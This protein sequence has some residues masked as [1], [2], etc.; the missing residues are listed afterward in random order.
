MSAR[1]LKQEEGL[2]SSEKCLSYHNFSKI[3]KAI[4]PNLKDL[5]NFMPDLAF[6]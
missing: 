4:F 3:K 2:N 6:I 1:G 5:F